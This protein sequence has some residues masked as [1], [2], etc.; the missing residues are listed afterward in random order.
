[1]IATPVSHRTG[2]NCLIA[3]LALLTGFGI[4]A[5]HASEPMA[6]ASKSRLLRDKDVTII[7]IDDH[8]RRP[9]SK[10]PDRK[11]S[12]TVRQPANAIDREDDDV[13]IRLKHKNS[14]SGS[15]SRDSG[16][17]V[18]IVDKH[19]NGC[20]GGGVCVIRP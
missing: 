18:I 10:T 5:A 12:T 4:A 1:M 16:P 9:A 20:D 6:P 3:A 19:S 2:R 7:I 17:K 11:S 8:D 13:T 15:A 14:S